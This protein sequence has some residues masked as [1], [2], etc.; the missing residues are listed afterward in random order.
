MNKIINRY[1]Y[2]DLRNVRIVRIVLIIF[3][4]VGIA[5]ITIPKSRE[6]F[7]LLTPI[8]L[9]ISFIMLAT[10]HQPVKLKKEL[11]V[12]S[13]IF[14]A[15]F[16]IEA[17]GVNTGKIFGSYSYGKGLGAKL[18][19]TPLVIGFNW[20]MLVYCTAGMADILK[21]P[22]IAKIFSSSFLMLLYDVAMEQ[23][24]PEIGMWSFTGETVPAV[25]YLAWFIIAFLFHSLLRY[26]GV[27]INNRM[28]G[29]IFAVQ[30]LFF[31]I[32]AFYFRI[33]I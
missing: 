10:F 3:F 14:L 28:A 30:F 15:S 26:A 8:A 16:I 18:F 25:N 27:K 1:R 5:G 2:V 12:F 9:L 32:L 7:I 4:S 29:F 11:L 17:V 6:F 19:N 31:L 21:I 24:A 20:V 22:V 33:F 23:V 13:T